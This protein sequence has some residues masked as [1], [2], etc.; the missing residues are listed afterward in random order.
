MVCAVLNC[1]PMFEETEELLRS[2]EREFIMTPVLEKDEFIAYTC[3]DSDRLGIARE[4]FYYPVSSA[5]ALEV[6]LGDRVC[7]V[8][9]AGELIHSAPYNRVR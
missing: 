7:E 4:T 2:A 1:G 3:P 8:R 9:I 6:T 5:D